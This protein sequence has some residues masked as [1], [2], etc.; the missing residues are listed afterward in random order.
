MQ[1]QSHDHHVTALRANDLGGSLGATMTMINITMHNVYI[2]QSDAPLVNKP[3]YQLQG[4]NRIPMYF[5]Q[6]WGLKCQNPVVDTGA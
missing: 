6:N 1:C 4:H 2:V 5:D 3:L